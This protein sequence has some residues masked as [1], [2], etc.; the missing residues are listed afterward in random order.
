MRE[1]LTLNTLSYEDFNRCTAGKE[2]GDID[3]EDAQLEEVDVPFQPNPD[4]MYLKLRRGFVA[5]AWLR[6]VHNECQ[7]K[8]ESGIGGQEYPT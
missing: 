4:R 2:I 1:I 6:G 5:L 8:P 7:T 3:N